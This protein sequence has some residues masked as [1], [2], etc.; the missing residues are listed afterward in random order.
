M[1]LGAYGT[2]RGTHPSQAVFVPDSR[3]VR[4]VAIR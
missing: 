1:Y 3:L 2:A 4:T